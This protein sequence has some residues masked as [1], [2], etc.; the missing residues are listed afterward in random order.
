MSRQLAADLSPFTFSLSPSLV[1]SVKFPTQ[2]S[3]PIF[4][5]NGQGHE[6]G[7][8]IPGDGEPQA[9]AVFSGIGTFAHLPY[10]ECFK[11]DSESFDIAFLGLPFDT[12]TSYRP[13]AR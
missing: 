13:G 12:G 6:K 11:K 2:F 4:Y 5:K 3:E 9:E 8:F 1:F 10:A 7:A